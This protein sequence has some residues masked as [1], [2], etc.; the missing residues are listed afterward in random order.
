MSKN[1]KGILGA[2]YGKVGPVVGRKFREENV[3]SAYQRNV[4]NPRS[5]AQQTHRARFKVLSILAH[6]MAC[7]A[8]YGFRTAAKGTN[9]SP[10]NLFQKTNFSHVTATNP[11]T[12]NV[13]YTNLAV[14][15]GG[16]STVSFDIP[17][18]DIPAAVKVDWTEFGSPCHRTANDKVAIYVYCPNAKQGVLKN[19]LDIADQTASVQVPSAWNGMKVHVWGFVRNEGKADLD[20]D[21]PAG[22][23]SPSQYLG[24]GN[25][26]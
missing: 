3:Y 4:A 11:T 26:G 18:F 8:I 5:D 15:K 16:L 6:D 12:T 14:S 13:D 7:G 23:C 2:Q 25:I 10:R 9:M 17:Q 19:G 1:M 20:K 22:E 24:S 21:I